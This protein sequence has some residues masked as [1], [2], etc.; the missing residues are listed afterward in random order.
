MLALN[1]LIECRSFIK[2]NDCLVQKWCNLFEGDVAVKDGDPIDENIDEI[3]TALLLDMSNVS[4]SSSKQ[5][6]H[7]GHLKTLV[8]LSGSSAF[9]LLH[10]LIFQL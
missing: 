3:F 7:T 1:L 4:G 9:L 10:V 6:L 2:Y 5:L 8:L